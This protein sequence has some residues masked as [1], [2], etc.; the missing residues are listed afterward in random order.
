MFSRG[1]IYEAIK[2]NLEILH[3]IVSQVKHIFL[4][5]NSAALELPIQVTNV[6]HYWTTAVHLYIFVY[7]LL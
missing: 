1:T 4:G 6:H 2:I 3:C 7:Q 5:K